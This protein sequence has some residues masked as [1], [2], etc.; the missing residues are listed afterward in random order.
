MNERQD[1]SGEPET[2]FNELTNA[3]KERVGCRYRLPPWKP[4]I[5][6][7]G[8]LLSPVAGLVFGLD[9]ALGVLVV[10][11]AFTTWMAWDGSTQVPAGDA[12]RL[13]RAAMLNGVVAVAGVVLIF[14]RQV[15]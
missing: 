3:G 2:P 1:E 14:L 13:R 6:I 8:V 11:M 4:L 7:V 12:L 10:A 9:F 5:F 15:S